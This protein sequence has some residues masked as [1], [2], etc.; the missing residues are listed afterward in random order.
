MEGHVGCI[1]EE[2]GRDD[3]EDGHHRGV[4]KV[5]DDRVGVLVDECDGEAMKGLEEDEDDREDA[6]I[7]GVHAALKEILGNESADAEAFKAAILAAV[8]DLE[9]IL[10]DDDDAVDTPGAGP[11]DDDTDGEEGEED[12]E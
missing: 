5:L 8:V 9:T 2:V 11:E 1:T 4:G 10:E 6:V 3:D 12:E 7:L